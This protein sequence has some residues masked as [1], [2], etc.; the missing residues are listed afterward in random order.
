MKT[1]VRRHFG[2]IVW[3]ALGQT[4]NNLA[5]QRQ[6][7]TQLTGQELPQEFTAEE[8]LKAIEQAFVGKNVLLVLDDVWDIEH[9][10]YFALIDETTYSRVLISS[11]VVNTLQGCEVVNI[12]LPTEKD[13]VQMVMAAAGMAAGIAVPA[14]AHVVARLC[15][16]LPLT[17]V[18][19]ISSSPNPHLILT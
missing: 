2:M 19:L 17:W 9:I 15:K 3:V 14:E 7:F 16:L 4:P 13:A 1:G 11:R 6:L 12:G 10:S 5:C 8:K 18:I